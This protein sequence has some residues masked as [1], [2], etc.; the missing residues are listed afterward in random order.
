MP[1]TNLADSRGVPK[2]T[3]TREAK[4]LT[5]LSNL[6]VAHANTAHLDDGLDG[7]LLIGGL[8]RTLRI[9]GVNHPPVDSMATH[10]SAAAL[11]ILHSS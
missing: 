7:S 9:V 10:K 8:D 5:L 4:I 11:V 1:L 3:T 6:T 2:L